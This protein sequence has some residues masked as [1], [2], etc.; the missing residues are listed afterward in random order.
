LQKGEKPEKRERGG[1]HQCPYG[2][3]SIF[4]EGGGKGREEKGFGEGRKGGGESYRS[5]VPLCLYPFILFLR[6]TSGGE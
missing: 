3:T 2:S 5:D 4:I 6:R 1:E